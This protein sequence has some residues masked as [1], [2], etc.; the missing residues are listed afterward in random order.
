[1]PAGFSQLIQDRSYPEPDLDHGQDP[2]EQLGP[3]SLISPLFRFC[4]QDH[5]GA[6]DGW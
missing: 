3:L 1:L 4:E 5:Y 2:D 6:P